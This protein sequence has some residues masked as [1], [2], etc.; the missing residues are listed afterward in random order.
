M[1][2]AL[3]SASAKLFGERIIPEFRE[4]AVKA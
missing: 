3:A 1:P 4:A 2:H